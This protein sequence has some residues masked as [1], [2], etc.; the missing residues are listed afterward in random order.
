MVQTFTDNRCFVI[1]VFSREFTEIN[2]NIFIEKG[3]L[4]S[5]KALHVFPSYQSVGYLTHRLHGKIRPVTMA[6]AVHWM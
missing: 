2:V 3:K 4:G 1:F 6:N 5:L